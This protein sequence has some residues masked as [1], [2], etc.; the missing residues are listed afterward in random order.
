MNVARRPCLGLAWQ[1]AREPLLAA[2]FAL[3]VFWP[4]QQ[5]GFL[6]LDDDRFVWA[7]PVVRT[8]LSSQ[9]VRWAFTTTEQG[10]YQPLTWLTHAADVSAFGLDPGAH[11]RTNLA[12]HALA[13]ALCCI[14]F[15][16]LTG[17]RDV[18]LV[19]A[20]LYAAHPSRIEVVAWVA[21]RKDLVSACFFFGALWAWGAERRAVTLGLYTLAL[22]A[23][24]IA[25]PL[26]LLLLLLTFAP[27]APAGARRHIRADLRW[28]AP[29]L[30]LML[31][32]AALAMFAQ[33]SAGAMQP[34]GAIDP[35]RAAVHLWAYFGRALWPTGVSILHPLKAVP[36]SVGLAAL[37]ALAVAGVFALHQVWRRPS[38]VATGFCWAAL[39]LLPVC[40]LVQIGAQSIADRW[41]LLPLAG[42]T[43]ALAL[44]LPAGRVRLAVG[45]AAAGLASVGTRAQLHTFESS[46][47]VFTRALEL[48]ADNPLVL[49]NLGTLYELRGEVA[50]AQ[51]SYRQA[52][53]LNPR[54]AL[55]A[56]NLGSLAGQAGR[57]DEAKRWLERALEAEPTFAPAH[58]NLAR[59]L[60]LEGRLDLAL[61]HYTSAA[62]F[63]PLS[64]AAALGHGAA[65]LARRRPQE[66]RLE[67][68][69][70]VEL[71]PSDAEAWATL[72]RAR[73][74]S[75]DVRGAEDARARVHALPNSPPLAFV[76]KHSSD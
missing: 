51:K 58:L 65:L 72:A 4:V 64:A 48:D 18:G 46:E 25:L 9:L 69:R 53:A 40:G 34:P 1:A 52:V 43:A 28:L 66:A 60:W 42:L 37:A 24:P 75:G 61:P 19:T 57:L 73:G 44:L 17:R 3:A 31:A 22:L 11:H 12:L 54:S 41:L 35:G 10:H 56:N 63:A 21:E 76:E 7:N 38:L 70:A 5:F 59:V 47:A 50:R 55:A 29:G 20:L 30:V 14:A 15:S 6:A 13:T 74:A 45:V 49:V 36:F 16:R 2:A 27:L 67:L 23:K 33:R 39:L 8:G 71:D 26:P 68:E 32:F 62:R